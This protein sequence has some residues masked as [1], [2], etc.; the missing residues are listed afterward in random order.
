MDGVPLGTK[1]DQEKSKPNLQVWNGRAQWYSHCG[2]VNI[3]ELGLTDLVTL[4]G[5]YLVDI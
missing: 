5:M 3:L 1:S 4:V 2:K